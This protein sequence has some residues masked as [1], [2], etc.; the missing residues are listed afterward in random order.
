MVGS[1][2]KRPTRATSNLE[3]PSAHEVKDT[4]DNNELSD[5]AV[6][7]E[8]PI[9]GVIAVK[10]MPDEISTHPLVEVDTY[11]LSTMLRY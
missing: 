7:V 8:K 6:T 5:I 3:G 4:L 1:G 10:I 11:W 9:E 2:K